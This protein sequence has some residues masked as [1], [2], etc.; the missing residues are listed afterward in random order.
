MRRHSDNNEETSNPNKIVTKEKAI[1]VTAR[2]P[3]REDGHLD[4]VEYD[5]CMESLIKEVKK[6]QCWQDIHTIEKLLALTYEARRNR[7]NGALI[8]RRTLLDEYPILKF[9]KWV[10]RYMSI[11]TAFFEIVHTCVILNPSTIVD[12]SYYVLNKTDAI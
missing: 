8:Q 9:K 11:C 1:V 5:R 10:S 2:M 7:I 3:A 6:S 12:W 4:E